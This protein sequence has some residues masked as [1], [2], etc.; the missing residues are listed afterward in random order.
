MR[1]LSIWSLTARIIQIWIQI[2]IS[3]NWNQTT[4]KKKKKCQKIE[5]ELKSA[6][7]VTESVMIQQHASS[8]TG[9]F[10][11]INDRNAMNLKFNF[12]RE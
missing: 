2:Q 12:E 8:K 10:N 4:K 1:A 11:S 3:E 7:T 9:N 5:T 6:A